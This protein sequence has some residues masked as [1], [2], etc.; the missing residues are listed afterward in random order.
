[1]RTNTRAFV[2]SFE[3]SGKRITENVK[4]CKF[5][6]DIIREDSASITIKQ[7]GT[8]GKCDPTAIEAT[9]QLAKMPPTTYRKIKNQ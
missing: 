7:I 5:I 1:M 3:K 4:G 8:A 2:Y 9:N 6:W